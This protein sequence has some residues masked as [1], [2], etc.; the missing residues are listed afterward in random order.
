MTS[1]TWVEYLAHMSRYL[2][3]VHR[4]IQLGSDSII[5]APIR[6]T[7]PI[8]DECRDEAGRLS[9][10]CDLLMQDVVAR[11]KVISARPP[12]PRESPHQEKPM[13]SYLETD[14]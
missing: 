7:V 10:A 14:M 11:M 2:E 12:S 8:P 5:E 3:E 9:D 13:A 1:L 4:S 6:P